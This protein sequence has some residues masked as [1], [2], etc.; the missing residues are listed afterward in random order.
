M[1]LS[2]LTFI[3]S[4]V[5][6]AITFA[7]Y[8]NSLWTTNLVF[9]ELILSLTIP[10]SLYQVSLGPWGPEFTILLTLCVWIVLGINQAVIGL[11]WLLFIEYDYLALRWLII[12]IGLVC[13]IF[14]VCKNPPSGKENEKTKTKN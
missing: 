9:Y 3:V 11:Y 4:Y 2:I 1:I 7:N 10:L 14:S 6:S 12:N 5:Y 13:L 8:T